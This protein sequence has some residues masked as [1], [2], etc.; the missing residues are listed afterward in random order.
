MA[1]SLFQNDDA[2]AFQA[3]LP[4]SLYPGLDRLA[5]Q[6]ARAYQ[7]RC[8]TALVGTPQLDLLWQAALAASSSEEKLYQSPAFF[9][10]LTE[11]AVDDGLELF[12]VQ[13]AGTG[14]VIGLVPARRTWHLAGPRVGSLGLQRRLPA[15]QILG[16]ALMLPPE[17]GALRAV[18]K[19]LFAHFDGA[20]VVLLQAMPQSLFGLYERIGPLGASVIDGWR[21]CHTLPLP[22]TFDAYLQK[23]SSKKRY[24]LQR[25]LR[26]LAQEAG[27]IEVTRIERLE[28]AAA[29]FE[30]LRE[31]A[32]QHAGERDATLARFW[33]LAR[34]GLLLAYVVRC[35]GRAVAVVSG[36]RSDHVWHVHNIFC[37]GE[38]ARLSPGT[39]AIYLALQDVIG[40]LRLDSVDFGYGSPGHD[41]RS[42]HVLAPRGRVVLYR[43]HSRTALLVGAQQ[44]YDHVYGKA[45]ALAK[46]LRKQ[47][48]ERRLKPRPQ[49]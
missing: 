35:G 5:A 20:R 49:A 48:R 7:V 4:Q 24:N 19:R 6:S 12:A 30:A 47:H 45:V 32:P 1:I 22:D 40:E 33:G 34:N 41:F 2:P 8:V 18:L 25:Q 15:I 10:Y 42:S 36:T 21:D 9:R 16:S 23:F 27:A 43:R 37:R 17:P 14:E 39:G 46:R 26:L 11:S 3:T 29:L 28:Q 38:Y 31:L 13:R 44:V